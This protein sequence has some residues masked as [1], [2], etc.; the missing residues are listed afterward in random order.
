MDIA[1]LDFDWK[2]VGRRLLESE[3]N[4]TDI[5]HDEPNEQNRREKMLMMWQSQKGSLATY[6]A[7]A[8]TF[9]KLRY[10]NIVQVV[11][12]MEGKK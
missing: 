11:K 7:L 2:P 9:E 12:E 10:S 3:Q 6:R 5:L 8:E 4:I 1:L